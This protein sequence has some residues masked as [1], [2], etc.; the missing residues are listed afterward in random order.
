VRGTDSG[1]VTVA[2]D[3]GGS[4]WPWPTV[5]S[6]RAPQALMILE[7]RFGTP[8]PN[9]RPSQIDDALLETLTDAYREARAG[10]SS[11]G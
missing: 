9:I 7:E 4:L 1:L 3:N 5:F 6:R 8:L 11:S 10:L 2:T